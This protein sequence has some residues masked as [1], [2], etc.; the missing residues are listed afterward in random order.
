MQPKEIYLC[1]VKYR[2]SFDIRPCIILTVGKNNVTIAFISSAIDLYN[3]RTHFLIRSDHPDFI[4]TGLKKTSFVIGDEFKDSP[5]NKLGKKIGILTGE[6]AEAF[7]KWI[8]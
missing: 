4:H 8:L 2:E 5:I 3:H 1:K 6:L 7:D